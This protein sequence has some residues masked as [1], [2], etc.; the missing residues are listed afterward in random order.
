LV[1]ERA[2]PTVIKEV[3]HHHHHEPQPT[4]N[5]HDSEVMRRLDDIYDLSERSFHLVENA[6]SRPSSA[7]GSFF[8]S[9]PSPAKAAPSDESIA[10]LIELSQRLLAQEH[11]PKTITVDRVDRS[12]VDAVQSE[13]R[14]V[15]SNLKRAEDE[16]QHARS[17]F[18]SQEASLR[19]ELSRAQDDKLQLAQQLAREQQQWQQ[20]HET[21]LNMSQEGHAT[22]LS[23]LREAHEVGQ[24]AIVG[25]LEQCSLS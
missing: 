10:Q 14:H 18:A 3:E 5:D 20:D 25:P 13:L 1:V 22:Q 2:L 23:R 6:V 19:A 7:N 24:T 4:S 11:A 15:Q 8:A 9:P 16:L 17:T 12:E 21:S